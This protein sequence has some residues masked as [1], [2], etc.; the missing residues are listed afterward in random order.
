VGAAATS[1]SG[2]SNTITTG[3]R[4]LITD[5]GTGKQVGASFGTV[6][7]GT[8]FSAVPLSGSDLSGLPADQTVLGAWNF[9]TNF[10][11]D[12]ALL[13]FDIGTGQ[14]GDLSVWHYD[15]TTWTPFAAPDLTYGDDGIADFAVTGFSG[16]A[17][18]VPEPCSLALLALGGLAL[19]R[20]RAI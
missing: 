19:L 9:T 16:Y 18:T 13:S 10:S 20:R 7:G 12:Q 4:L 5:S 8:N 6:A 14:T 3:E 1:G 15:G 11:G 17:V 2:A